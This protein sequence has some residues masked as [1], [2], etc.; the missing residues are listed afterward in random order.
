MQ[1]TRRT[2]L[3]GAALGAVGLA[4]WPSLHAASD[5]RR[6]NILLVLADDMGYA[7]AECYGGEIHTPNLSGLAAGGLRFT[8][9]YSTGR[10]WPS[11]A[12]IL[13]GY[14]AQHIRRD[15]LPGIKVGNRPPWALLLPKLLRSRGY[16]AYHSGKWHI[17]GTPEEGGF[18]RSWGRHM[19]G[20][21]WNRYFDSKPWTE[22]GAA[23]PVKPGQPYYS[24]A[25]IF[26]DRQLLSL[27]TP[28][29]FGGVRTSDRSSL[30]PT[31]GGCT[32]HSRQE[33]RKQKRNRCYRLLS[34]VSDRVVTALCY[35][36]YKMREMDKG[37]SNEG[38]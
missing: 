14:Y 38:L 28:H 12:C 34:R 23:A 15:A 6:P 9:H 33:R 35:E 27:L 24:T 26:A 4:S 20:C 10:C 16:R 37:G 22:D 2:F 17:D 29:P 32:K 19:A 25:A 11:R 8:Q 18:D 21:D 31:G 7:D 5:R 1:I 30:G 13:T 3:G 36:R